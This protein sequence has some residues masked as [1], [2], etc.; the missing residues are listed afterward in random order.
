MTKRPPTVVSLVLVYLLRI[1]VFLYSVTAEEKQWSFIVL[2]DWHSA[3]ALAYKPDDKDV[4]D[5]L[6]GQIHHV[7]QAYGGELVVLPGDSNVGKWDTKE[8]AEKFKPRIQ[9]KKRVL[10]A[11]RNCYGA[12]RGVFAEAGYEHILMAV[13]DHELGGNKWIPQS[14]KVNSLGQ[15]R[16]GFAEGFNE[17]PDTGEFLFSKDIGSAPSRPLNTPF[18]QT[19]YAYQHKNVLFITLD[20]F[21]KMPDTFFD[22]EHGLGG[23]GMVTC[24]IEGDHLN[25]FESV[26]IEARKD[27]SIKHIIV[28][29]HLPIIQPVRKVSCSGQFMDLGEESTL[30]KTM[31]KYDVDVYLAGEVH[32]NTVTKDSASNLLQVVSRGNSFNNFLKIEVTDDTLNITSYNE[33][34]PKPKNNH[35]YEEYGNLFLDKAVRCHTIDD[36]TF[37]EPSISTRDNTTD[38]AQKSLRLDTLASGSIV[39][40]KGALVPI[41]CGSGSSGVCGSK[42]HQWVQKNSRYPVKCCSESYIDSPSTQHN[43]G[44]CPFAATCFSPRTFDNL[45]FD[46]FTKSN[47]D[48]GC[49]GK[50]RYNQAKKLCKA[51]GGSLCTLRELAEDCG[52]YTGC[53]YDSS[54]VWARQNE[55]TEP[56]T[57]TPTS[58]EPS[59]LP[60]YSPTNI[61]TSS[62]TN[63]PSTMASA[64]PSGIPSSSPS[65]SPTAIPSA[66]PSDIPSYSPSRSPTAMPTASPSDIP[67]FSPSSS[68][69]EIPSDSPSDLPTS[70][71]SSSPTEIPSRSPS[72]IPSTSPSSQPTALPSAYP[73]D[74]PTSSPSNSPTTI[75]SGLP[76]YNPTSSPSSSPTAMPSSSPS[77]LPTAIPSSSPS[78]IPT[79]SPSISPTAIPSAS[80]S[81][82]PSTSPSISPTTMPSGSPSSAPTLEPRCTHISSSGV[83]K[84]LNRTSALIHLDFKKKKRLRNR[85]VVGMHHD[86]EKKTLV[87]KRIT[88]RGVRSKTSL[89]NRGS[90][91]QPYDAQLAN[92]KLKY[93]EGRSYGKFTDR[94]RLA[95]YGTGPHSGGSMISYTL[96]IKTKNASDMILVHYGHYFSGISSKHIYTLTLQNGTPMLYISPTAT[97]RPRRKYDLNDG[98]WHHIAVSMPRKSCTLSEVIIYVDGEAI[99]TIADK[100][101]G[102]IFFTTSG[103]LSIGGFGYSH[104]S[105]EENF[106]HLSPFNGM[107]DELYVWGR[108][109][110]E[111]DMKL[112]M[113]I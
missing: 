39:Q 26:L 45:P 3:E 54:F 111:D 106:P 29:A 11:G 82:I 41:A 91:D 38:S 62:P 66:S 94:S 79:S 42:S 48:A 46:G 31:V 84:L 93:S 112:L 27:E 104:E 14:S 69:T 33:I 6:Y 15:Y 101:D 25:W 63:L 30:W 105:Y 22:K 78:D 10:L 87:G 32:T 8:F 55:P 70:S 83:L 68:P 80:P 57:S 71:P 86:D 92:V 24:T 43:P 28:Q 12:M 88:I 52:R 23:E 35:N 16:Q 19:S 47:C 74:I 89:P 64:S 100:Y 60:S 107:L 21:L 72:D 9:V 53:K 7:K 98:N 1:S 102:N 96:W 13:G 49:S 113:G 75:P 34:G 59:T 76:S 81:A 90:F 77:I 85:Q 95:I 51:V 2:A 20:A 36:E 44:N 5:M 17:E 50:V 103:R 99:N 61:P 4:K 58:H 108:A 37:V 110:K 67:S 97:L 109:L 73:S 40:K 65:R 18:Q 56:P